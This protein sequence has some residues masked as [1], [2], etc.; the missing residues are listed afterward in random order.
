MEVCSFQVVAGLGIASPVTWSPHEFAK[1]F[2]QKNF[3]ERIA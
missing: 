1:K 3:S 2:V